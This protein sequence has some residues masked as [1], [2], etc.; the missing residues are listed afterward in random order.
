MVLEY[1]TDGDLF[2]YQNKQVKFFFTKQGRKFKE[3]QAS[4]YIKQITKA[5]RYIHKKGIM[6]RDIKPENILVSGVIL[7]LVG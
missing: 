7:F 6:H 1:A 2:S 5:F 3:P 4:E